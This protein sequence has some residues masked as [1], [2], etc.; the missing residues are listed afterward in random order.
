MTLPWQ[1]SFLLT[2]GIAALAGGLALPAVA[3]TIPIPANGFLP[4]NE[5]ALFGPLQAGRA[6]YAFPAGNWTGQ[7]P[8]V[9]LG[10]SLILRQLQIRAD[11]LETLG[12]GC[13][14]NVTIKAATLVGPQVPTFAAN[15]GTAWMELYSGDV[16]VAVPAGTL[17]NSFYITVPVRPFVYTPL[18]GNSLVLDLSSPDGNF[19]GVLGLADMFAPGTGGATGFVNGAWNG[20]VGGPAPGI[21]VFNLV[22][23]TAPMPRIETFA[24]G[25]SDRPSG[26]HEHFGGSNPFDL[27]ATG[28]KMTRTGGGWTTGPALP[29][30]VPPLSATSI[31]LARGEV[32]A[33][34]PLPVTAPWAATGFPLPPFLCQTG[35]CQNFPTDATEIRIGACGEIWFTNQTDSHQTPSLQELR[36]VGPRLCALWAD[37]DP[38]AGGKICYGPVGGGGFMVTW[39]GVPEFGATAP[40]LFQAVLYPNGDIELRYA[41]VTVTG[42]MLVGFTMGGRV[43]DQFSKAETGWDLDQ[44]PAWALPPVQPLELSASPVP[45]LGATVIFDVC[46][47]PFDTVTVVLLGLDVAMFKVPFDLSG[48]MSG[49]TWSL[50]PNPIS[51]FSSLPL[52]CCTS[53]ALNIPNNTSFAGLDFYAQAAAINFLPWSWGATSNA[54]H[55]LAN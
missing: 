40:N 22:Y 55:L 15:L 2:C 50:P 24:F 52:S 10:T 34:I 33:A 12:G 39:Q 21:P 35:A 11:G 18:L 37:L 48:V 54:L 32:S 45:T 27:A 16:A 53:F 17:P 3:Q 20:T 19:H 5:G 51:W 1:R 26:L 28:I 14:H 42:P 25:C 6:Q 31:A 13:L 7:V 44:F 9:A 47:I 43:G 41:L 23:D 30:A 46:A 38:S 36:L 49:C 4:L 8:P 29:Y